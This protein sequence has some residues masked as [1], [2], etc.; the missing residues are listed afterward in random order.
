MET[1]SACIE[2]ARV[3]DSY[4]AAK[5]KELVAAVVKA[6]PEKAIDIATSFLK[7]PTA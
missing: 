3:P 6:G 1:L 2:Y 7:N 5:G 4:W